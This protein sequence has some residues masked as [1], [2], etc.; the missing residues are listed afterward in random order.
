MVAGSVS[1]TAEVSSLTINGTAVA[2]NPGT[3]PLSVSQVTDDLDLVL[4]MSVNPGWGGQ[5]FILSSLAKLA[6]LP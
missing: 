2:I 5:P 3:P 1:D 6:E 4:C